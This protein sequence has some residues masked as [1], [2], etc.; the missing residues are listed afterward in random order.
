MFFSVKLPIK[1]AGKTYTPCICYEANEVLAPTIKKLVA[2]GKAYEFKNRV[3]FQNGK[4]IN[5]KE[6]NTCDDCANNLGKGACTGNSKNELVD[7]TGELK[8]F[9][10]K[11]KKKE[12]RVPENDTDDTPSPEEVADDLG[13]F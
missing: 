4:V 7:T 10:K 12:K 11:G 2:D 5:K 6:T 13:G 3:Y 9:E 8:C 1:I